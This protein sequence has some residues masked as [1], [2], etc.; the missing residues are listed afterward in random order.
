MVAEPVE[1][2]GLPLAVPFGKLRVRRWLSL[3]LAEPVEANDCP[4]TTPRQ[5][6]GT[7]AEA[8]WLSLSLGLRQAP[9]AS[10]GSVGF[11]RLSPRSLGL[12]APS[13]ACP[14]TGSG[15]GQGSGNEPGE[16]VLPAAPFY[17]PCLSFSSTRCSA[18]ASTVTMISPE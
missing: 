4:L 10:T 17:N 7:F 9:W 16:S 3:S 18:P 6:R 15:Q 5:A 2:N 14:S 12:S 13:P 8:W 11:D 1:A